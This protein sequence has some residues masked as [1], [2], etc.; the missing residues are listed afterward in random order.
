MKF[1]LD[2]GLPR[3]TIGFLAALGHEAEHVGAI[4]MSAASDRSILSAGKEREAVVVTLDADFHAILALTNATAPSVIRIRIQGM[5]G[6]VAARVI[7]KVFDAAKED[8]HA[9][10]AATVTDR[11]LAIRRLPLN[12]RSVPPPTE[13]TD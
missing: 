4:G 3:S 13:N 9:G 8:L 5:K 11:R 12:A 6:E 2:Q 7:Q 1:L 10:V